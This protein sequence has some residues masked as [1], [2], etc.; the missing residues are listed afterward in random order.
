MR[1]SNAASGTSAV[2]VGPRGT[3]TASVGSEAL[4]VNTRAQQRPKGTGAKVDPYD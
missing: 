1:T 4:F 2:Q 3:G